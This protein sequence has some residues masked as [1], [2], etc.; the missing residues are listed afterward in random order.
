MIRVLFGLMCF[1]ATVYGTCDWPSVNHD[2]KN[3][4]T[5]PCERILSPEN[6]ANLV[7][8]GAIPSANNVQ[9]CPIIVNNVI[10]FG[11]TGGFVRAYNATTLTQIWEFNT[12]ASIDAPV[13]YHKGIIYA[14]NVAINLFALDAATGELQAGWPAV[15]DPNNVVGADILAAPV[16]VDDIVIVSTCDGV[17]P[18]FGTDT[19]PSRHQ[20]I[21]AFTTTGALIWRRVIQPFP[22]GAQGGSFSTPAIDPKLHLMFI[23]T[24][25]ADNHPV[26]NQTDALLALDYRTGKKVWSHQYTKNDSWGA[27]YPID[28]DADIG[29]SPNL[30]HI[31]RHGKKIPVVGAASKKGDYRVWKRKSGKLVWKTKTVPDHWH[32][33]SFSGPGAAYDKSTGLIYVP[34][35]IDN[36]DNNYQLLSILSY[37]GNASASYIVN[38]LISFGSLGSSPPIIPTGNFCV[39]AL[40]ANTGKKVWQFKAPTLGSGS[41]TAAN[42]VV[43]FGNWNGQIFALDGKS[44]DLLFFGDSLLPIFPFAVLGGAFSIVDGK[45]YVPVGIGGIPIPGGIHIFGLP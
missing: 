14:A 13:T 29:A 8:V 9:V 45:L 20:S 38:T 44:G 23:G 6:V 11:D 41:V 18:P 36:T 22:S 28:P 2:Y 43:Y 37:N 25:N 34:V 19:N 1:S 40:D 10:Y 24:S 4:R 35:M 31:R 21:S 39:T 15:V 26:S 3:T 16:I 7:E 17:P 27:L 30:F 33:V 32:F 42:G 5:N 12:G